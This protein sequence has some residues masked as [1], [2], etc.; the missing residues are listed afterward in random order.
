M[1]ST[2]THATADRKT[3]VPQVDQ[4]ILQLFWTLA[5]GNDTERVQAAKKLLQRLTDDKIKKPDV[6]KTELNYCLQRLVR[7]LA[8][9][10][11][12][13]RVGY[14]VALTKLLRE[15]PGIKV[16]NILDL[17]TEQLKVSQHD[18]KSEV[19]SKL[20]GRV[21]AYGALVQSE[22]LFEGEHIETVM[23]ELNTLCTKRSYIRPSST[24]C[25]LDIVE[26]VSSEVLSHTVWPKLRGELSKGW[27]DCTADR[28]LLLIAC[29]CKNKSLV[30]KAFL[31]EHW[32]A[33]K[34][35]HRNNYDH[36]LH[37]LM[38]SVEM[39]QLLPHLLET[40]VEEVTKKDREEI[41]ELW[42]KLGNPLLTS[43]L[44]RKQTALSLFNLLFSHATDLQ[45]VERM[46]F[47]AVAS[48]LCRTAD[49]KDS[50]LLDVCSKAETL[51]SEWCKKQEEGAGVLD[52]VKGFLQTTQR[53]GQTGFLR[54][55]AFSNI[56]STLQGK[57]VQMFAQ[58]CMD[59]VLGRNSF[60]GGE[61]GQE[62]KLENIEKLGQ[63]LVQLLRQATL[64]PTMQ[65]SEFPCH[66]LKFLF[67]HTFFHVTKPTKDILHC[68]EV[69]PELS[70]AM[71]NLCQMTF[72][73]ILS[74]LLSTRP[75]RMS[76]QDQ[77]LNYIRLLS[78][79]A[80]YAQNLLSSQKCV[81]PVKE[82]SA[83]VQ[84]E[85]K[86]IMDIIQDDKKR[87]SVSKSLGEA[88]TFKL[89]ILHLAFDLF[90]EP[91]PTSEL[92]QDVY[93]CHEKAAK[94]KKSKSNAD[95]EPSWVEVVTEV[96]L[97]MLSRASKLARKTTVA[98]FRSLSPHLTPAALSLVTQ[99][100]KTDKSKKGPDE[101]L[102]E[103]EDAEMK[104]KINGKGDAGDE[105]D[106]DGDDEDEGMISEESSDDD[107]GEDEGGD[108]AVDEKLRQS[109]KAALGS[110]AADSDEEEVEDLS[111]SEMFKLDEQLAAAFRAMKRPTKKDRKEK[112]Q[113][114]GNFR[115]RVLDLL[116]VVAKGDRCGDLGLE[117]LEP[118]LRLV[119]SKVKGQ[120]ADG[121]PSIDQQLSTRA[122]EIFLLLC[123]QRNL[124]D[125]VH[126]HEEMLDTLSFLLQLAQTVSNPQLAADV[127]SG[128]LFIM[129][130]MTHQQDASPSPLKTRAMRE[131]GDSTAKPPSSRDAQHA[132]VDAIQS[133]LEEDLVVRRNSK[134]SM[135]FFSSMIQK[136][137]AVFWPLMATLVK[138]LKSPDPKVHTKTK[139][140]TLMAVLLRVNKRPTL[141]EDQWNNF[142]QMVP[143]V[144]KQLVLQQQKQ[145]LKS[146]L[147][148]EVLTIF[149]HA[150]QLASA[151][152]LQSVLPAEVLTHLTQVKG[153]FNKDTRKM[154]NKLQLLLHQAK[155]PN[156]KGKK[157]KHQESE[158]NAA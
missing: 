39:P 97:S 3:R 53:T 10:R 106:D 116:E 89:L 2:K 147:M 71:R 78:D 55:V 51:I 95:G 15:V 86:S 58:I 109:V 155:S 75:E 156:K 126:S 18:T 62:Q 101:D 103:F 6:A 143:P 33:S 138:V 80:H 63:Q 108:D 154:N 79:L 20:L 151:D 105:D 136:Y 28:L 32:G 139:A 125:T 61:N 124:S 114:V 148:L 44:P 137:P 64:N 45:Q 99:V 46:L 110:A 37:L 40:V 94:K 14:A 87:K 120:T 92:L 134:Y 60:T 72:Y 56:T 85:W 88:E 66:V 104:D 26:H 31:K 146:G 50:Q 131:S 16:D 118:L 17:I 96:L 123:K 23:R 127:A 113:E 157:R 121:Q 13:A 145:G 1:E 27:E 19:G 76:Q 82:I 57:D 122:K 133:A 43:T 100:L 69:S 115:L 38:R 74:Q 67:L 119:V 158:G 130:L 152:E 153:A 135:A 140:C 129:R 142:M 73:K 150:G 30:D 102:F 132:F 91:G 35:L 21:F 34:V 68:Q 84:A 111:D 70:P 11:K 5:E 98:V 52:V 117:L 59:A 83:E 7:G 22:Q 149:F 141:S 25:L 41:G 4:A 29:R 93:V 128:C 77:V 12:F 8:S 65:R 9:N 90:T 112:Q 42:T 54:S 48:L 36:L 144:L 107:D 81:R 49:H 24:Q 47:P